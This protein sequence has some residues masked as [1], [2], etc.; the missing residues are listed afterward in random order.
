[1]QE[2]LKLPK[3]VLCIS[4]WLENIYVMCSWG[5]NYI[6]KDL[7]AKEMI[8]LLCKVVTPLY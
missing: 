2:P 1:M 3:A 8:A 4:L 6:Q 5:K 7:T